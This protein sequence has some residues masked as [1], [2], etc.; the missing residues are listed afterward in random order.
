MFLLPQVIVAGFGHGLWA[1]GQ[2]LCSLLWPTE[3]RQF[4]GPGPL[5]L[6]QNFLSSTGL[7]AVVGSMWIHIT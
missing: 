3:S 7:R 1:S 5:K 2:P 4:S 6:A